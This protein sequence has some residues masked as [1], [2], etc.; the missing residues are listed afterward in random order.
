VLQHWTCLFKGPLLVQ[1]YLKGDELLPAEI[2]TLESM[3]VVYRQRLS[4]LSWFMKC[5]NESIAR[6]ANKEDE[7]TGHFWEARFKSQA[8]LTEHAL[9]ACM[10]YVDLNPIRASMAD[11]PEQSD[12]TSIKERI[13]SCFALEAAVEEQL[14]QNTLMRFDLPLKPLARFE[15]SVR[16]KEQLGIM[17][18]LQDYLGLVDYTG[19]AIH[20]GKRG[21]IPDHLP[22]ILQ[23]L[24]LNATDWLEQASGFEKLY[25]RCHSR[26]CQSKRCH[27]A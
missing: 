20:P 8:L 2:Q 11:T 3:I 16:N 25:E 4:S 17:F 1:K 13:R 9:I 7:C 26:R 5:L 21:A 27:S 10:A 14:Q 15:G 23:R 12:H 22:P 24:G 6:E 19:R 18:A